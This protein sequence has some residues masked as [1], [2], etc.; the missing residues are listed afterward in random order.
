L[1]RRGQL[2]IDRGQQL[3]VEKGNVKVAL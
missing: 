3:G 2:D 1:A